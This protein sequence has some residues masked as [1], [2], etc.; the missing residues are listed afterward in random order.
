MKGI[1]PILE[2]LHAFMFPVLLLQLYSLLDDFH[3]GGGGKGGGAA[4]RA[5]MRERLAAFQARRWEQEWT[6]R[7]KPLFERLRAHGVK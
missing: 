4:R 7:A 1:N 3:G 2:I 5:A 6:E